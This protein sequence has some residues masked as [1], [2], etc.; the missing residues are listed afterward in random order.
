MLGGLAG[1]LEE[2]ELGGRRVGRAPGV[3]AQGGA[4][5]LQPQ[6]R[7]REAL[8]RP[9]GGERR[10]RGDVGG[11]AVGQPRPRPGQVQLHAVVARVGA[12]V[13]PHEA[14][15]VRE[16]AA[17]DE[18]EHPHAGAQSLQHRGGAVEQA[19]VLRPGDDRGERA[20]DVAEHDRLARALAQRREEVGEPPVGSGHGARP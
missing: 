5:L 10:D 4:L 2:Q 3:H 19:R 20:V 17:A 15:D 6:A 7:D 11:D 13:E 14:L 18:A 12:A 16:A 1:D 8:G 9:R